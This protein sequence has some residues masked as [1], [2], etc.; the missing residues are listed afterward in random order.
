MYCT[1]MY[2][3]EQVGFGKR[4]RLIAALAAQIRSGRLARGD[5]LPGENQ[6]ARQYEVSRGTVRSALAELAQ[7]D[8]IATQSGV[9]SFV[10]FDG[11]ALDQSLGWATALARSGFG[12]AT[13]LLG[14]E[15]TTDPALSEAYG[16]TELIA[17]RRLRRERAGV[18]VSLEVALVPASGVLAGLPERGLVN[19]SLT[20]TLHEAGLHAS[21]GEQWI[22]LE[23][24]D[25]EA[26]ALLEREAGEPFLRAVRISTDA[27]GRLIEHVV[28]LLDPAHFRFH[29]TFGDQ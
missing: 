9:G 21:G 13:V 24:L 10:T 29:L 26:A 15:R 2:R 19:D 22:G 12:V 3:S 4:N 23:S 11:V 28:S 8:L 25:A 14:I 18:P 7:Q 5:R 16:V 6:L 1:C 27:E 17:V 20:A